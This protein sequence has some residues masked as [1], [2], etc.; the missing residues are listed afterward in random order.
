MTRIQRQKERVVGV[1]RYTIPN[2]VTSL[3]LLLGLGSIVTTQVGEL[4]FAAALNTLSVSEMVD[5]YAGIVFDT[6]FRRVGELGFLLDRQCVQ[7][8]AEHDG[9]A[10]AVSLRSAEMTTSPWTTTVGVDQAGR[11]R[12]TGRSTCHCTAPVAASS[13]IS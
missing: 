5:F 2:S 4:E 11:C 1:L 8:G 9:G 10:F 12:L 13:L 6:H 3:S 7:V